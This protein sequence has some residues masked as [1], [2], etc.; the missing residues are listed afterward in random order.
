VGKGKKVDIG[1]LDKAMRP[2]KSAEA[3]LAWHSP[4][5][6]P[7]Q[8]A[9]FAW[10]ERDR[11]Y[12]RL[13]LEPPETIPDAVDSLANWTAGGQIR[14]RTDS[15]KCAVRVKLDDVADLNHMPATGQCGF[16]CYIGPAKRMR[17]VATTT[18]DHHHTHYET[19]LFE[20]AAREMRHVTLNFPLYMGVDEVLVGLEEDAEVKPPE[21]YALD[22]RV[23]VY[24]TSITQGGCASRPGMA[25]TD[26]LSRRIDIEFINLGFSGNGR[27]E[28]EVARTIATLERSACFVLDY[29]G[30]CVS[31]DLLKQTF[32]E[33]IRILREAHPNVPIVGVSHVRSARELWSEVAL[34]HRLERGA[35]QRETIE[36]LRAKGDKNVHFVDGSTFLGEDFDECA[37]DGVHPTDLGFLRIAEAMTPILE[38]ILKTGPAA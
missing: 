34:K 31:T 21:A 30:N 23:A 38:R 5:E 15:A 8:V 2:R 18:Y 10:F 36:G 6:P 13:P 24:G 33:F 22:G 16:D 14:L 20:L 32:P 29:E 35:F 4:K 1:K 9:G 19:V 25:W 28:A 37:V 27:G 12:R 26:I 3:P 11:V 17:Y 7:F